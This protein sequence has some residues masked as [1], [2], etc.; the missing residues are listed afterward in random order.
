MSISRDIELRKFIATVTEREIKLLGSIGFA[1]AEQELITKIIPLAQR[2]AL[3]LEQ[4][5]GVKSSLTDADLKNYLNEI[6]IEVRNTSQNKQ[7]G[8]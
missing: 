1:Q 5:S 7:P 6:L 4:G 2:Q 3:K 8:D